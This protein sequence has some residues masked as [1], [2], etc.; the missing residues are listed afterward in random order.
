MQI[1]IE[2]VVID[3]DGECQRRDDNGQALGA[4]GVLDTQSVGRVGK[5]YGFFDDEADEEL[6]DELEERTGYSMF[7]LEGMS[8]AERKRVI[9]KAG[10]DP[11][12]YDGLF[13][14]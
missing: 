11:D 9:E 6:E 4:A 13:Q 5:D 10:L 1:Q 8:R 2:D 14:S 12:D 3:A 7:E